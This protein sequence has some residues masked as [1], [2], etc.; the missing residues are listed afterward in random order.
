MVL[1]LKRINKQESTCHI[2][3]VVLEFWKCVESINDMSLEVKNSGTWSLKVNL[4]QLG[5]TQ[6]QNCFIIPLFNYRQQ[7]NPAH[8]ISR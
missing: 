3:F 7:I 2:W 6:K 4:F 1:G 8:C 5:P